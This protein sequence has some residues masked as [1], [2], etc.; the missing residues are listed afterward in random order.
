MVLA[1]DECGDH[2]R[3]VGE[4]DAVAENPR[5]TRNSFTLGAK[6]AQRESSGLSGF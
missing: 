4:C 6:G 1:H 3:H 2:R 5:K